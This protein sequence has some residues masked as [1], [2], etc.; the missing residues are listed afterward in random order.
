MCSITG[1]QKHRLYVQ[2]RK[3]DKG[4]DWKMRA[5]LVDFIYSGGSKMRLLT[6]LIKERVIW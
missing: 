3:I 6:V 4:V 1:Q 5:L 2:C